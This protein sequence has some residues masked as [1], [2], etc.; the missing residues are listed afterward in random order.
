[1]I[2]ATWT[3]VTLTTDDYDAVRELWELAGLPIRP[4]GRDSRAQ[5]AAQLAG[6][7][8]TVIGARTGDR[9]VGVVMTTHDGRKGW[10]NRL[11]VHPDYRRHGLG[12]RLIGEAE[13]VLQRQGMRIIA[14]LIE[15]G[16]D[17]SLA[18]FQQA[19]YS[20]YPGIHYLTKRE[21]HDI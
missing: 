11:A 7:T 13:R 9:L 16:N 5:F 21:N 3:V 1:M 2:D 18:L 19:G 15:D 6:G 17:A 14:A 10:I 12:R 4:G 8:Q 20:D